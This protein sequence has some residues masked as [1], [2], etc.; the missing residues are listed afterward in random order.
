MESLLYLHSLDRFCT[1]LMKFYQNITSFTSEN[2][3]FIMDTVFF[4]FPILALFLCLTSILTSTQIR[5]AGKAALSC[6]VITLNFIIYIFL[7]KTI[8]MPI[9]FGFPNSL[10]CWKKQYLK[11]K[12]TNKYLRVHVQKTTVICI[13][14]KYMV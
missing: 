5:L 13:L 14:S 7:S 10:N 12:C 2:T 1:P 8:S 9:S 11:Q 3:V 4:V 6:R